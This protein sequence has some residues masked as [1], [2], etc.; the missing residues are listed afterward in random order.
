[1]KPDKLTV[2]DCL[3][4]TLFVSVISGVNPIWISGKPP[5]QRLQT[6]YYL[7]LT[8]LFHLLSLF[9][10]TLISASQTSSTATSGRYYSG[11]RVAN[12][13]LSYMFLSGVA[14]SMLHLGVSFFKTDSIRDTLE[15]IIG[16][17]EV[18]QKERRKDFRYGKVAMYQVLYYGL[19][20]GMVTLVNK[21]QRDNIAR[22]GF[23]DFPL[24]TQ[25][26]LMVP[27]WYGII[28]E[29]QFSFIV[30]LL[31]QRFAMI[32]LQL[33]RIGEQRKEAYS[34]VKVITF[35]SKPLLVN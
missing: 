30:L 13:G 33:E 28:L 29:G 10:T 23:R 16:V 31:N 8:T 21:L 19:T 26:L 20:L 4:P 9:S 1:M 22:E 25:I 3:R 14:L 7:K 24:M 5:N 6:N 12:V 17:D 27:T 18:L 32:N 35:P 2:Y 15:T 11:N 34:D